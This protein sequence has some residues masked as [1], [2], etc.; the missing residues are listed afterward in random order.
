MLIC[1]R[2]LLGPQKTYFWMGDEAIPAAKLTNFLQHSKAEHAHPT[3]AWS[4]QTGKGLLYYAKHEKDKGAP[5]GV[6]QLVSSHLKNKP[7]GC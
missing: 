3:A 5:S 1:H 7:I 2:N 4:S 6:I